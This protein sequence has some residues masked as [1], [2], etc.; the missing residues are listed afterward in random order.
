MAAIVKFS[1]MKIMDTLNLTIEQKQAILEI[2]NHE[3][4]EKLKHR[5]T[6]DFEHYL[7]ELTEQQHFLLADDT[8]AIL[9]WSF[10]FIRDNDRWFAM[11]LDESIHGLGYG[12]MLLNKLKEKEKK[13]NA[14]AIDHDRDKKQNGDSYISPLNFYLKNDFTICNGTRLESP[15]MSAV[16]I[17]WIR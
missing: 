13:L 2:W 10:S 12:T 11:I 9:G 1:P 5:D 14:W 7:N 3:Y 4:P 15:K 16:K 6:S 17:E 8:G